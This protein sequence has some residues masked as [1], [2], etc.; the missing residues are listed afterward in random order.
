VT[1]DSD[2]HHGRSLSELQ[3][4][5]A[6]LVQADRDAILASFASRL[7]DLQSPV[8]TDLGSREQAMAIAEQT[9]SD[10]VTRVRGDDARGGDQPAVLAWLAGAVQA[11]D[12]LRPADLLRAAVTLFDVA[13]SALA[14]HVRDDPELLPCFATAVLA[15]NESISRRV[16][17][18]TVAY[19]GYLLER[20]DQ[21]HVEERLRIARD[22]HDRLGEGLSIALR[23]LELHE[24]DSMRDPA[25]AAPRATRA[26]QAVTEA[27]GRLRAVTSDLRQDSVRNLES[28]LVRYLDS[29]AADAEVE[30]RVSGDETWAPPEVIDE[31]YQVIREALRN[32]F[33]HG[34]PKLVLIGITIA[35][36]ELSAWVED[37]GDGFDEA[38]VAAGTGLAAMR[39]RAAEVGGRLT[40]VSVPGQGTYVSLV[41]SL[42]GHGNAP[43]R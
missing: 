35:P 12:E 16:G 20:V 17:G 25:A 7:E 30:L 9:V 11:K 42:P 1:A 3:Q 29:I 37:D 23:Q 18:A 40:L 26:K 19:T 28:A 4:H 5:F 6:A 34:S 36:H 2:G 14:R 13:V 31:A 33:T 38:T 43:S 21:A 10:V 32:A 24:I 39:E 8:S 15:L 27:M 41:V 22:L